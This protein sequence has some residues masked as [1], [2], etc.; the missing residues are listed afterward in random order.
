[1]E[2]CYG[3]HKEIRVKREP[4]LP[5]RTADPVGTNYILEALSEL[6]LSFLSFMEASSEPVPPAEP[7]PT[8]PALV[9]VSI[10]SVCVVPRR[11]F[12]LSV[13][14][15]AGVVVVVALSPGVAAVLP[16]LFVAPASALVEYKLKAIAA[17]GT[18]FNKSDNF[19]IFSIS[20][21]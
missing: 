11:I 1:M 7:L 5:L 13:A 15:S 17:T 4:K 9:G 12:S 19:M 18:T 6:L 3:A 21:S 8:S 2:P 10:F 14:G 20:T 16:S